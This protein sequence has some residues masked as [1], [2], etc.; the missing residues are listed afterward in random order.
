MEWEE[1]FAGRTESERNI[2]SPIE[3]RVQGESTWQKTGV[4]DRSRVHIFSNGAG[5]S[6]DN[7]NNQLASGLIDSLVEGVITRGSNNEF[8]VNADTASGRRLVERFGQ[9]DANGLLTATVGTNDST[10]GTLGSTNNGTTQF[11]LVTDGSGSNAIGV[12]MQNAL[13]RAGIEP[14]TREILALQESAF[15]RGKESHLVQQIVD[16]VKFKLLE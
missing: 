3:T 13:E 6:L 5:R 8:L 16:L 4:V 2:G 14:G 9:P 12:G 15:D 10:A 11:R 7:D 1:N